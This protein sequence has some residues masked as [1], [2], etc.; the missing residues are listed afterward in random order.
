MAAAAL[1]AACSSKPGPVGAPSSSPA[2]SP[3]GSETPAP[4]EPAV[5]PENT[6]PGDIPDNQVFVAYRAA[7]GFEVKVPEGWAK[8]TSSASATFTDKLNT[9]SMSWHAASAAPT[10]D[11]AKSQEVPELQRSERAFQLVGVTAVSL[12]G[13][14]AVLITYRANSAPNDVTGKQ[15]RLDVQ[16]FE[17]YRSG[18]EGILVLSSP[19]GADNVDPWRIVSRSFHWV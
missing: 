8:T 3:T 17:L 15:Y 14:A 6:P 10:V 11:S 12:P 1:L 5:A 2:A 4:T 16:R 19:V 13:G 18:V 9:V 7:G